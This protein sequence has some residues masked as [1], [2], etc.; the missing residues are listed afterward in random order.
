SV[1]AATQNRCHAERCTP[2]RVEAPPP[3]GGKREATMAPHEHVTQS[4]G[5]PPQLALYQMSIGHYLSRALHLAAQLGLADLL[6]DGPR[7]YEELARTTATHP[8]SLNRV[9]RLL[10]SVGVFDEQEN[11]RFALT[12]LGSQLRTGVPGSVRAMVML[13]AG[14][15]TQDSWKELEHCVRT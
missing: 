12:S 2:N 10:A 13:F 4:Q 9:M 8:P 1:S 14:P 6:A 7:H 11:G 5:L 3:G 15:R